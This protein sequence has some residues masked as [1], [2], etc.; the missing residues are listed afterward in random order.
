[1]IAMGGDMII[2]RKY[3]SIINLNEELSD[4]KGSLQ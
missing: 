1:M 2:A 3:S 4:P